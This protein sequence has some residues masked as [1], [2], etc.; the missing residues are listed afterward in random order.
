MDV[1]EAANSVHGVQSTLSTDVHAVHWTSVA[2]SAAR[3]GPRF[4][5]D[6]SGIR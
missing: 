2:S 5:G 3:P 6:P 4:P 1:V